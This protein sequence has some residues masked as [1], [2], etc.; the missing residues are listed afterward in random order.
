MTRIH[1]L[2]AF[3]V[4]AL[5]AQMVSAQ[6]LLVPERMPIHGSYVIKNI[7]VEANIKDQIAEVQLS[8]VFRN[9]SSAN[10]EVS[11]IFPI[12]PDAVLSQFT[13]IADGKELPAKI[14]T[15][16]EAR[17]I[18]ESIV[19]S[20]RDPALLEYVGY[21]AVQTSI[22]PLPAHGERK[23]I[24]RY[25]QICRRDRE[26]TEMLLPLASG[27]LS[28]KPIEELRMTARIESPTRIK[29][30]YSP[31]HGAMV[32]RPSE[33][34]AVIR[35]IQNN[36][37]PAEDFRLLWS[38]SDQSIGANLLSYRPDPSEDG[39][40]IMLASPEVRLEEKII[41]KTVVFTLDRSGS[42]AGEKLQQAKNAL[43]FVLNNLREGDLFNIVTFDGRVETFKPELQRFNTES[44]AE[45]L[46]FVDGIYEGG[47]TNIDGALK[48][49]LE[50]IADTGRPSYLL[51]LTDGLPTEGE[52]NES[53]IA[54]NVKSNNRCRTRLFTF[55]VGYDV[56]SRLLD[57]LTTENFGTSEYVR[58]NEN[59]ETAV[60]KFYGRMTAPVLT[61]VRME[62]PGGDINRVYPQNVPD[63]FAGGQ[64]ISVGRY[65]TPGQTKIRLS[66][67]ADNRD[68]TFEFQAHLNSASGDQTYAFVEKLWAIRRVGDIINEL[69][70]KGKNE[71][72]ILELVRL[73]T[74]HG[75]LTPY[76]S[77]LAD[78]RTELHAYRDNARYAESRVF[79]PEQAVSQGYGG[80]GGGG[81][82]RGGAPGA[83]SGGAGLGGSGGAS[84]VNLRQA[85]GEMQQAASGPAAGVQAFK[86]AEGREQT[87]ANCQVIANKTLFRKADRWIDSTVT[88][89]DEK[90]AEQVEQ[91]SD[92][93][94]ELA[95]T[96]ARLRPY[97]AL[98][99]GCIVSVEGKVYQINP[100][101]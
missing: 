10:M 18:Y 97:L 26:V 43:K 48:R 11:Y 22:F 36:F 71:E 82:G 92:R 78:E 53:I 62:I 100:K 15:R 40:F 74:K 88:P 51:F 38:L 56:N 81:G 87:V 80:F 59:I 86:D 8:Q 76:T 84:G 68:Q 98:I 63:M 50:L 73:S 13:L 89:E 94:F 64:I 7:S 17:A 60:A 99:D 46:R 20:R 4:L 47:G 45:S 75:I 44:R 16:E 57:R 25:S 96:N 52:R 55:G 34:S 77:F 32:E 21:G 28:A 67:R 12:P 1:S 9:T 70:L 101:K 85:K 2:F 19:R 14:Y 95:R 41:H 30:V 49:A 66:G 27:K 24:L 61:H 65:R 93:Y 29:S 33:N 69:D 6:I 31:T 35:F 23:I 72:L 42:M 90:K 58:P 39:Y 37:V 54:A 3:L 79:A 5:F 83:P 91:F